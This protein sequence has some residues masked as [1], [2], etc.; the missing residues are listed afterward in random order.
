MTATTAATQANPKG[1]LMLSWERYKTTGEFEAAARWGQT[2]VGT[3]DSS[4][5]KC[6]LELPHAMGS[7]WAMYMA[8]FGAAQRA[9]AA[10]ASEEA[11]NTGGE[12]GEVWVAGRIRDRI[13]AMNDPKDDEA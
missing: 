9:A 7:F 2:L 4:T 11:D 3:F 5:F 6:T 10:I 12:D 1:E 13:N 8:G